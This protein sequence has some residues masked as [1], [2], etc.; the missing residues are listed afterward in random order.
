MIAIGWRRQGCGF[1]GG[2]MVIRFFSEFGPWRP[3]ITFTPL[4]PLWHPSGKMFTPWAD[5]VDPLAES[6]LLKEETP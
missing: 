3:T 5:T 6:A 2:G 1:L 4:A